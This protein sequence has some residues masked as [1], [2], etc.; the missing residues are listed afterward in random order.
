MKGVEGMEHV[1]TVLIVIAA[2]VLDWLVACGII[3]LITMCFSW[4]FSWLMATGVW[5]I[6]RFIRFWITN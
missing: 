1:L 5:L 6:S 2:D 4:K 3:K